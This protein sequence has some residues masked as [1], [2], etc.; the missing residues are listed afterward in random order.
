MSVC[1]VRRS[2]DPDVGPLGGL[3]LQHDLYLSVDDWRAWTEVSTRLL[4]A[5]ADIQNVQITRQNSGFSAR[6]RFA[7]LA[8][9]AVRQ[10]S[11]GLLDEG[12]ATRA[13][14]EHLL[15]AGGARTR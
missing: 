10:L 13:Q 11:A 15:L 5:G 3:D 7:G 9:E 8:A 14:V 4:E 12:V 2:E 6:C 1:E